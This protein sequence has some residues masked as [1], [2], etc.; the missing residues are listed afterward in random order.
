MALFYRLRDYVR[1]SPAGVGAL[2]LLLLCLAVFWPLL[3]G[4]ALF[5]GDLELYFYPLGELGRRQIAGGHLPLWN[6]EMFG[7]VSYAGNPQV[8]YLY[9]VNALLWWLPVSAA[10]GV[11]AILHLWGS[12]SLFFLWLRRG[13]HQLSGW[14]ALLGAACWML[15][16]AFVTKT[17]F[18]NMLAALAYLPA[19][20][21]ASEVLVQH[22]GL[23]P[24]AVLGVLLGL[25]LLAS[26]AQV[27][28]Y[29]IYFALIY[30][31]WIWK[32]LPRHTRHRSAPGKILLGW[33]M[34]LFLAG[35]L[36]AGRLLPV[37]ENLRGMERQN[38]TLEA[39]Q[40]FTL[41]VWAVTNLFAPYLYGNP[42]HGTWTY[43]GGGNAWETACY[44]GMLPFLLALWGA[45]K[46]RFWCLSALVF[47]LLALGTGGGLYVL[48]F[49]F[50]PGV[51]RFH[52]AARFLM[53]GGLVFAVMAAL[54]F[55]KWVERPRLRR[56]APLLFLLCAL[57]LGIYARHFYPLKPRSDLVAPT[58]SVVT[59]DTC[60]WD[61]QARLWGA[62]LHGANGILIHYDNFS[63]RTPRHD[64]AFVTGAIANTQIWSGL[65]GAGGYDP[66]TPAKVTARLK[67]LELE[68]GAREFPPRYAAR[69]G[70]ANIGLVSIWSRESFPPALGL[71]EIYRGTQTIDGL[72]LSI[73]RNDLC[74]PRARFSTPEG[75][76]QD[77]F[78]QAPDNNS[79]RIEVPASALGAQHLEIRDNYA[80]GWRAFQGDSRITLRS[81]AGGFMRLDL[82]TEDNQSPIRLVYEPES[83]RLGV[84]ISLCALSLTIGIF[85][86][87][88]KP[89]TK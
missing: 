7:G 56:F 11:S 22:P 67:A 75:G 57:D 52:D 47:L 42:N 35:L 6:P 71:R 15:G 50:L 41:P 70:E 30:T 61:K 36:D 27:S 44:V 48:A 66:L 76:F 17:Q 51:S 63:L 25:Q 43:K 58:P 5:F 3:N 23:R 24:T 4:K 9:P 39:A 86:A 37:F 29:T 8:L 83:F 78:V 38:L 18:P 21:W 80:P 53:L 32:G 72:R 12:G 19:I 65:L 79:L 84:F 82:A 49:T 2:S 28:L 55:Q 60:I 62:D 59:N 1:R 69:L 77:A 81:T 45:R 20:L 40:R 85:W 54:G 34:A 74:L 10:T 64:A 13:Q 73:F 31:V 26:H 33:G 68:P 88:K 16:G 14:P 87:T 89:E 46:S